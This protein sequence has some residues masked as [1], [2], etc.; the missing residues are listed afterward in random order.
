MAFFPLIILAL[1]QGITEFLPISSSGHLVIIHAL[2]EGYRL[3]Q[4]R[5]IVDVAVHVGT[6]L[7]V[8]VYF[9]RD[10]RTMA[11]GLKNLARYNPVAEGARLNL[12]ILVASVPVIVAGLVLHILH[13]SWLGM[14]ELMAWTTVIFGV[15]LWIADQ[16]PQNDKTLDKMTLKEAMLI[17]LAQAL[18]LIPGTSRSGITMTA[19]RFLGYG[20]T[21]SAHFS[22][23]LAIIAI[24]G[25]GTLETIALLQNMNPDL[26]LHAALG[27]LIAFVSGWT[28]IALMM[29]FLEKYSFA[30]FAIY[31]IAV[32]STIL[33][34]IYG[35][36]W[37]P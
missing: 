14:V 19:A 6:L 2:L 10:V 13:P 31:R 28:A 36:I 27:A 8:L 30:P 12:N 33:A 1:V 4:S 34:L 3:P 35:G 29:R 37:T 25:A 23:L 32:G 18:A 9:R 16:H 7:A 15:L 11:S 5:L 20:R 21:E 26:A 22:L 17:G 24:T